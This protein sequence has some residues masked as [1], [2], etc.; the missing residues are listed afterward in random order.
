MTIKTTQTDVSVEDFIY[1]FAATPQKKQDGYQLLKLMK[2]H[3]G[4]DP[5]TLSNWNP[6]TSHPRD[7]SCVKMTRCRNRLSF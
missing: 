6:N 1:E 5:N 3:T 7:L 4:Y 2:D